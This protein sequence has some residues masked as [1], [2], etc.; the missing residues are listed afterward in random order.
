MKHK[1]NAGVDAQG[2]LANG[3]G[4]YEAAIPTVGSGKGRR[5]RHFEITA[6][7][8]VFAV[9]NATPRVIPS[10]LHPCVQT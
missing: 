1:G 2:V 5:H 3:N 6:V 9:Q 8:G 4:Y 7:R 10:A